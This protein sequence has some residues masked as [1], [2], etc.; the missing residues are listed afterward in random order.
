MEF[1]DFTTTEHECTKRRSGDSVAEIQLGI[2]VGGTVC[3]SIAEVFPLGQLI[4]RV[5][6]G[7]SAIPF[8]FSVTVICQLVARP[9]GKM[10]QVTE[11][12]P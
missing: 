11:L 6:F 1:W 4:H 8:G 7:L 10:F 12:P 5:T 2:E 3:T 9:D